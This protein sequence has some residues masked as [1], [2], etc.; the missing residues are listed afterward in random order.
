MLDLPTKIYEPAVPLWEHQLEALAKMKGKVGFAILMA[1]RTGKSATL[2][3]DFGQMELDGQVQ[4]LLVIAPAGVC[5]TWPKAVREH[6]SADLQ[7]RLAVH[8]WESKPMAPKKAAPFLA[9]LKGPRCLIVNIEALSSKTSKARP[10][11][12]KFL[13][14]RRNMVAI[15]ES[16]TIKNYKAKRTKYITKVLGPIANYRRILSGLA[17]PRS[18]LDL[19]CQFEFLDWHILQQGS[20]VAFRNKYAVMKTDWFGG[21]RVDHV[22]GFHAGTEERLRALIEPYSC[23]VEF[24][25]KIPSTYSMRE[26]ELTEDQ[27]KAY[28]EM[29][30]FA[31]TQLASTDHVTATVV[32]AQIGK[33]HQILCGHVI[34]EN[35]VEHQLPENRTAALIDE[36]TDYSG[37]AIVWFT[38]VTDLER[39][40]KAVEKEFGQGCVARFYGGNKATRENDEDRFQNDPRCQFMFATAGAGGRGRTWSVADRVVYFSTSYDLEHREQ[41]EQRP[42]GVEKDRQVD[43]VD[44]VVPNSVEMK[45]LKALREK[46]NM[47]TAINGD[48][49]KEWLI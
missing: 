45:I 20:F 27:A 41:S 11:C 13:S 18:P 4:D 39:C 48:T 35:G 26:I 19:Y 44:F 34:D 17:T 14:Q 43:F 30:E 37:K 2:L 33:L 7:A 23:R 46:I 1:M 8:V 28:Q 49:Y 5:H 36:L 32:V 12:E 47:A 15:D 25:P 3:A 42:L 29:L 38:Y 24:R 9:N 21:R 40:A 31:T 16:T 22:V 10:V 6:G